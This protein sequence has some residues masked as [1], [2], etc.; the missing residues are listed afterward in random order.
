MWVGGMGGGGG[1]GCKADWTMD[2]VLEEQ[3]KKVA[4]LVRGLVSVGV[5]WSGGGG[6]VGWHWDRLMM[7]RV[8]HGAR[9]AAEEL[10]TAIL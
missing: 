3:L 1:W 9:A 10:N 5:G 6:R 8:D 2:Q 4:D 7:K